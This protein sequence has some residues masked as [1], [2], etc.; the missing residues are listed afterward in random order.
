MI[1]MEPGA[2][3]R[4]IERV[5]ELIRRDYPD[6]KPDVRTGEHQTT[7]GLWG[8][9]SGVDFDRLAAMAGVQSVR[10]IE[11]PYKHVSRQFMP[12]DVIVDVDGLKIGG[13]NPVAFAGGTCSI[14]GFDQF[15]RTAEKS[16]EAGVDLQRAGILKPRKNMR[17]FR[18]LA[19]E[20][21][22]DEALEILNNAKER[23]PLRLISEVTDPRH[24]AQIAEVVD[25]LQIGAISF[26]NEPLLEE[27][28]RTGKPV[29]VK[30]GAEATLEVFLQWT[31][32]I[33]CAGNN[34]LMLCERGIG[35]ENKVTPTQTRYL[36]DIGA[37]PILRKETPYPV[38]GDDS[39][40]F[41]M[42]S[43]IGSG[44]LAIVAAG[45]HGVMLEAHDRPWEAL[46]DGPQAISFEHLATVIK[47]AHRIEDTAR[48]IF[49]ARGQAEPQ[50][51]G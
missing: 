37:I 39:H 11:V 10:P 5:V 50:N 26:N 35:A 44:A 12:D 30:R 33:T 14:E 45:A 7:I 17:T 8:D 9:E 25:V 6:V 38:F 47:A 1:I 28:A 29:F 18:G 13:T 20:Q 41:G 19:T 3:P 4:H 36:L 27:A 40:A 42:R 43:L 31:E 49:E 2:K 24:V 48:E 16:I 32:R 46:S 21:G 23:L 15:M 51:G 34:N 22:L